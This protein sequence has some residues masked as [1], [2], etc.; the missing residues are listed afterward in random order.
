VSINGGSSR[1]ELHGPGS[2]TGLTISGAAASGSSVRNMV[3]NGFGTG[4]HVA[5][6]TGVTIAG[7]F[8]GTNAAGNAAAA[9]NYGVFFDNSRASSAGPA[10]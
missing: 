6:T 2:G 7:N 1:V 5:N 8:I 9:N 4:I 10:G 3:I